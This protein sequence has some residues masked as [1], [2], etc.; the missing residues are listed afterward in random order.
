MRASTPL[1]ETVSISANRK[2]VEIPTALYN[3]IARDARAIH[4]TPT[5]YLVSLLARQLAADRA[6]E[7]QT[8]QS[9]QQAAWFGARRVAE[10]KKPGDGDA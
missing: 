4:M 1:E 9:A 10:S 2:R 6:N 8:A 7:L 5:S 3:D